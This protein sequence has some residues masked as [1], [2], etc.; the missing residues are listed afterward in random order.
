MDQLW[1]SPLHSTP[2]PADRN[3]A[4]LAG[5]SGDYR[6]RVHRAEAGR[7]RVPSGDYRAMSRAMCGDWRRFF[8]RGLWSAL[9]P[10]I[11]LPPD[12]EARAVDYDA[13][14]RGRM[15]LRVLSNLDIETPS[16]PMAR[17]S[18]TGS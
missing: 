15:T 7:A 5:S 1:R 11:G 3:I 8:G 13:Q 16:T 14:R 6:P 2:R 12:F 18:S 17:L 10:T 4:E 9:T